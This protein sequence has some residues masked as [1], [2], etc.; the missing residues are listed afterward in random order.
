M[1]LGTLNMTIRV[2]KQEL[3]AYDL[4]Q[5]YCLL[6]LLGEPSESCSSAHEMVKDTTGVDL[7]HPPKPAVEKADKP[8]VTM[9]SKYE[10]SQ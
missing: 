5:G 7:D 6:V 9:A 8:V 4:E 3:I 10:I 2:A 1:A